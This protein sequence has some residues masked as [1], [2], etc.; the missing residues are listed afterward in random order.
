MPYNTWSYSGIGRVSPQGQAEEFLVPSNGSPTDIASGPDGNLWFTE[1]FGQIG[2]ISTTGVIAE[3]P[4][5]AASTPYSGG[6]STP[7]GIVA[8]PDGNL[9][10]T[11]SS[12]ARIGRISPTGVLVMFPLPAPNR[13]PGSIA[14]GPDNALW[15]T[16]ND[17]TNGPMNFIARMTLD[18]S[19]TEF[20]AGVGPVLQPK[21]I[22]SAPDG[23]LWFTD[24]NSGKIRRIT[25]AG[26][27]TEF[28]PPTTI[29]RLGGI[30]AGSDGNI[31]FTE[32]SPNKIGRLTLLTCAS[33][34]TD[35]CLGNP[36]RFRISVVWSSPEGTGGVGTAHPI[37]SNTGG[38]W[39]FDP[40]NLELV[41]KVLDGREI[42]GHFWVFYGSLTNVQFTL[43]VTDTQTGA[44]KTYF[45]PQGQLASVA[46]TS[47]F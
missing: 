31:W 22:T 27:I 34:P 28:S 6:A 26:S 30:T 41:V 17:L 29:S 24:Y 33:V 13:S 14:V 5:P 18:G 7:F 40:T 44:V 19:V 4:V 36:G 15:F 20:P 21:T 3:F 25:P 23:N 39:F 12:G 37:T 1:F 47:A 16:E 8:G 45:N 35:L 11:E 32:L 9:W 10:F 42:D 38:F 46:D 43:T 2:R